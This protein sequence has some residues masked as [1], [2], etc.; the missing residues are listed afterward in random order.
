VTTNQHFQETGT[1]ICSAH[2]GNAHV[3]C[4]GTGYG[5]RTRPE[6]WP[7]FDH[8]GQIPIP[9]PTLGGARQSD[10]KRPLSARRPQSHVAHAFGTH[11]ATA[12][13]CGGPG[14]RRRSDVVEPVSG[15]RPPKR[16]PPPRCPSRRKV[17][18]ALVCLEGD[19]KHR[20]FLSPCVHG[21]A[22]SDAWC[23]R[24]WQNAEPLS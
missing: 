14:P 23:G 13:G 5:E 1:P 19:T 24:L 18:G 4:P 12:A 17:P 22:P 20:F 11:L 9:E 7:L 8:L 15:T 10:M 6:S 3:L 21:F 16:T 2:P